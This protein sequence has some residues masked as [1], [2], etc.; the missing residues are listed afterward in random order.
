GDS[1]KTNRN[2]PQPGKKKQREFTQADVEQVV[3]DIAQRKQTQQPPR[4]PGRRS[5]RDT[6]TGVSALPVQAPLFDSAK[7]VT[8]KRRTLNPSKHDISI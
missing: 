5:A 7:S 1:T 6:G 3:V 2:T 8:R 4:K